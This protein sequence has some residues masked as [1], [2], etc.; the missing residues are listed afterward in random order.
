MSSE[1]QQ[2]LPPLN[3][4]V[5][6]QSWAL[7]SVYDRTATRLK[8][9]FV[10]RRLR[11]INLTLIATV[12]SV[13]TGITGQTL[14]AFGFGI[15]SVT[16]PII[17]AYLMNDIMKF[18][19]TTSWV[20]YRY[21]AEN[22]RMHIYLYRMHARP[23]AD[24]PQDKRDNL[25]SENIAKAR[26]AVQLDEVIPFTVS[27]P[28]TPDEIKQA[29]A[30]AN[31]YSENESG[32]N[33]IELDQYLRWRLINQRQW[34]DGKVQDDY[35]RL[36]SSFRLSQGF[37]LGGALI[38]ALAGFINI[39]VITLVAVTNA[40]SV[41]LTSWST[42]SM[43]GKTYSLFLVTSLRLGDQLRDWYAREDDVEMQNEAHRKAAI[44]DFAKEIEDT[45]L[46][47][48]EEWYKLAIQVQTAGDNSIISN[49]EKLTQQASG[50][51]PS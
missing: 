47:E 9:N 37:L 13:L 49:L 14:V 23:Y 15:M 42:V 18:T 28:D 4:K 11:V 12:A 22:I 51:K 38:S 41:A 2:D 8:E 44:A 27:E 32:L 39:Q 45:L 31:R 34:Y 48:R 36:K 50:N 30:E 20:K 24:V 35:K 10:R 19:G 40:I 21:I 17:G 1:L 29:I 33:K 43:F 5:L 7:L 16:L 6:L 26:T 25:L 3:E 46:Q